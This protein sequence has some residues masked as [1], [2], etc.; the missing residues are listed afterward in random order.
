M[1]NAD[2]T[3]FTVYR[4]KKGEPEGNFVIGFLYHLVSNWEAVLPTLHF[5]LTS[6]KKKSVQYGNFNSSSCTILR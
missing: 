4:T 1:Q 2:I 5:Q 6:F 3:F